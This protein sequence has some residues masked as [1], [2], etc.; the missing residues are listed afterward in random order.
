MLASTRE[1]MYDP[2]F[3]ERHRLDRGIPGLTD[4]GNVIKKAYGSSMCAADMEMAGEPMLIIS[5][6]REVDDIEGVAEM[7]FRLPDVNLIDAKFALGEEA[8]VN[9]VQ[10]AQMGNFEVQYVDLHKG[11]FSLKQVAAAAEIQE[12][13]VKVMYT[14]A[15]EAGVP[16]N[17]DWDG[18]VGVVRILLQK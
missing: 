13:P 12:L 11:L 14:K 7:M 10:G 9:I 18:C 8:A 1:G 4:G 17:L 2:R 3:D 16:T 15:G 6:V 5:H